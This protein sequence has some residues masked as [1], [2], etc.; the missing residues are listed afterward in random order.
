MI[1]GKS[2]TDQRD[3]IDGLLDAI[4]RR[5][6]NF[7]EVGLIEPNYRPSNPVQLVYTDFAYRA[8]RADGNLCVFT[9]IND[10]SLRG[11][12]GLPSWVPDMSVPVCPNRLINRR[13]WASFPTPDYLYTAPTLL[14]QYTLLVRGIRVDQISNRALRFENGR[15]VE[16]VAWLKLVASIDNPYHT[17]EGPGEVLWRTLL[18]SSDNEMYPR[19]IPAK[20]LDSICSPNTWRLRIIQNS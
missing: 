12:L 3:K 19:Q 9:L 6:E 20:I 15:R 14:D 16:V 4:N 2:V 11:I 18:A 13:S 8:I 17:N 5:L 10:E 1:R 7:P